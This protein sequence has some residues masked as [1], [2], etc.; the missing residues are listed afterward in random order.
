[1]ISDRGGNIGRLYDVYD[2]QNGK[3]LRG[4]FIIDPDGYINAAEIVNDAVGRNIDEVLRIIKA[5]Q[6]HLATGD[7][8]PCGWIEGKKTI[9]PS[10]EKA[11]RIWQEWTPHNM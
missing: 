5:L 2:M 6:Y 11:G 10:V 7:I 8:M 3:T 1:M 9:V 4:T